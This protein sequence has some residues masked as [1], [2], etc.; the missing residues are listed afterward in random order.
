MNTPE[1]T[2]ESLRGTE[3]RPEGRQEGR[4]EAE[5]LRRASGHARG[6]RKEAAVETV[7][8]R[9]TPEEL[10]RLDE[11]RGGGVSRSAFIRELLRRSG[12]LDEDPSYGEA[13][14][15]LARSARAGKVQAQVALE[16]SLRD[17][18][19]AGDGDWL[20]RMLDGGE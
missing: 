14:R 18:Q 7:S 8:I 10:A 16:R 19:D 2:D 6:S 11:L 3:G 9:L 4:Q 12:P 17:A 5:A 15:L 1:N 13:L 20:A